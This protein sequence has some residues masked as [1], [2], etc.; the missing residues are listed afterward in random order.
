MNSKT[1]IVNGQLHLNVHHCLL[2]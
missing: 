2:S 1:K